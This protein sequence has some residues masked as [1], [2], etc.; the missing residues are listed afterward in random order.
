MAKKKGKTED[1]LELIE[2]PDEAGAGEANTE[3]ML[4]A[5]QAATELGIDARTLRKFLRKQS[6]KIGQGNRWHIALDDIPQLRADYEKGSRSK[7]KA[8]DDEAE[9]T[10]TKAKPKK[11]KKPRATGPAKTDA[12]IYEL[13]P[14]ADMIEDDEPIDE[15]DFDFSDLEDLDEL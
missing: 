11:S 9:V 13:E 10:P 4:S 8:D 2:V 3:G 14:D 6:G 1:E 7:P 12:E 5:K 15:E